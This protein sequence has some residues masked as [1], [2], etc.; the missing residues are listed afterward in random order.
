MVNEA[1]DDFFSCSGFSQ[2][3]HR[4]ISLCD[5][6]HHAANFAHRP[7]VTDKEQALGDPLNE[8]NFSR[9]EGDGSGRNRRAG[10]FLG[11]RRRPSGTAHCKNLFLEGLTLQILGPK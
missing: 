6:I 4:Q 11:G 1:N 5:E 10:F 7:T 8:R 3:Q 2:N 9:R